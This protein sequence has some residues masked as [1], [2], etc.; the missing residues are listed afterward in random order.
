MKAEQIS[1]KDFEPV[2]IS[3]TFETEDEAGAFYAIT[4]YT[5]ICEFAKSHGLELGIIRKALGGKFGKGDYY[6]KLVGKLSKG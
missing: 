5:D 2:T 1:K 4:N 6:H 3:I